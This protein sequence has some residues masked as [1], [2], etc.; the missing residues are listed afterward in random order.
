MALSTEQVT[1]MQVAIEDL[2]TMWRRCLLAQSSIDVSGGGASGALQGF[3]DTMRTALDRLA[4]WKKRVEAGEWTFA[5]WV[6]YATDYR[7][8]MASVLED[9]SNWQLTGY[10]ADVTT[11]TGQ[12]VAEAATT[13]AKIGLPLV[14]LLVVGLVA[15]RVL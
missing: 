3:C 10:L 11:A 12:E 2:E 4:E 1:A 5:K 14:V 9:S 15:L 6:S 13:A 8:Q 7:N